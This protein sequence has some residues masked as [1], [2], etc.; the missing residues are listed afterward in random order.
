MTELV[1]LVLII[2]TYLVTAAFIE[3]WKEKGKGCACV[4][5]IEQENKSLR[6]TI[7]KQ[8]RK[9]KCMQSIINASARHKKNLRFITAERDLLKE[10][11]LALG[12]IPD[13]VTDLPHDFNPHMFGPH[14]FGQPV[15]NSE[16]NLA[17]K[18]PVPGGVA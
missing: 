10:Q 12:A 3:A 5:A 14:Q 1:W 18:P 13:R 2:A 8:A 9:I 4:P 11:I 17:P 16:K 7:R 6:G 15:E